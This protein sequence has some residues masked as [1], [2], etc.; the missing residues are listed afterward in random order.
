[1]SSII[2]KQQITKERENYQYGEGIGRTI[3]YVEDYEIIEN[4]ITI[5]EVLLHVFEE[6]IEE[7]MLFD[8]DIEFEEGKLSDIEIEVKIEDEEGYLD[9]EKWKVT[10]IITEEE[11]EDIFN[12]YIIK[13][14]LQLIFD[15]F[16]KSIRNKKTV[17]KIFIERDFNEFKETYL[18]YKKV[19]KNLEEF[20]NYENFFSEEELEII[21]D[22]INEKYINSESYVPEQTFFEYIQEEDLIHLKKILTININ[23]RNN[24]KKIREI[25]KQL[26]SKNNNL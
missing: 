20:E 26:K 15:K 1:M 3:Q 18:K 8:N 25:A 11:L 14:Q 16:A 19:F 7:D 17:K 13:K 6:N 12:E 10:E 22:Y 21:N 2:A 5:E 23:K 24:V 4:G 9:T